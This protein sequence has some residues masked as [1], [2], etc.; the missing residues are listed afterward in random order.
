MF[1]SYNFSS[2][3][4]KSKIHFVLMSEDQILFS[5][6]HYTQ[7]DMLILEMLTGIFTKNVSDPILTICQISEGIDMHSFNKENE[8]F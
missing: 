2:E 3:V 5:L 4:N 7:I 6:D 1:L 8:T